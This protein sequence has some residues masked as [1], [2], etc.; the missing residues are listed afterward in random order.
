MIQRKHSRTKTL[1]VLFAFALIVAACGGGT[2]SATTT[3]APAAPAATTTTTAAPAAP[4]AT[5]TTTAAPAPTT[6]VDVPGYSTWEDVLAAADGTTVNWFMWGGSDTINSNVDNDIGKVMK[7]RYN[8][9]L[10][11]VPIT[12]TADVV[13]KVLDEAAAG[14]DS[15]GSVDLIW[16]N[17]ENFRTLKS[18]D[19]LYGPWSESIPNAKYVAW[20]DPAIAND[21]GEPVDGLESPWGHAQFVM[22]YNTAFVPEPPTTFEALSDWV[23]ANPGQFTYP[24]I[25]DFTGSVFV[26]TLFYWAAG[27]PDEFLGEFDQAVFDKYA[28]TVWAYLNDLEPDLWRGGSTYPEAAAMTDLLANQE[29]QFNMGYNPSRASSNIAEGTYPET[30]RTFVFDTG[31]L[32][33]NNY[34]TIP[35]NSANPAGAMVVANYMVSPEFSLIMADPD[36][37][38][39]L[40]PTDPTTW[41]AEDQATLDS[42]GTGVATLPAAVLNANALPEPAG[43]WVTAMEAGWIKNV[44]EN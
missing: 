5:T 28:P 7:E 4:A 39:W 41:P 23:K 25:P 9:T 35:F 42:Y 26:R 12:D 6:P 11:R 27:G 32:S 24:A 3:K 31:T 21:F 29:I 19:L 44:L 14:V 18:A 16:I 15:G 36:Q 17:G 13:N 30:I 8:I 22:E 20:D 37:W 1:V 40:I 34:V 33:N 38:G 43:D 10:N 2:E